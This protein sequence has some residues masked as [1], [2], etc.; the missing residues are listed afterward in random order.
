M[1]TKN[2]IAKAIDERTAALEALKQRSL[3]V[4]DAIHSLFVAKIRLFEGGT[5]AMDEARA[6]L[7]S[8]AWLIED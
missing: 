8:T 1:N 3:Q 6:V 2:A 5:V 7:E 4:R